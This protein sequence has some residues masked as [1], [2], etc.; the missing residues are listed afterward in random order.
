[1]PLIA[2]LF[3]HG[4]HVDPDR[5]HGGQYQDQDDE[6]DELQRFILEVQFTVLG[7]VQLDGARR[8]AAVE[9]SGIL[10]APSNSVVSNSATPA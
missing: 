10:T 4:P 7:A 3:G 2:L 6:K 8:T 1:M 5:Q 9:P